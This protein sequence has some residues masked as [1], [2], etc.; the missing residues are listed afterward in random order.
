[1]VT[2]A[3]E[4]LVPGQ[5]VCIRLLS[6]YVDNGLYQR[7]CVRSPLVCKD[8]QRCALNGIKCA[9][10]LC[11]KKYKYK[12]AVRLFED[13]PPPAPTSAASSSSSSAVPATQSR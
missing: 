8:K 11:R 9:L 1:M 3:Q 13:A 2:T 5:S 12:A 7:T 10:L 6:H 4:T